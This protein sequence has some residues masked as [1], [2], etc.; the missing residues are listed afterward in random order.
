[1]RTY[2]QSKISNQKGLLTARHAGPP[3]RFPGEVYLAIRKV[4]GASPYI[5]SHCGECPSWDQSE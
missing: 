3:G 2:L 5:G 4:R 1:L